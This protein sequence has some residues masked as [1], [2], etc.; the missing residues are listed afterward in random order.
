MI[1]RAYDQRHRPLSYLDLAC[2]ARPHGL[3]ASPFALLQL[4]KRIL[5]SGGSGRTP[6]FT[7]S[8]STS[9]AGRPPG[10]PAYVHEKTRGGR[11]ISERKERRDGHG[12]ESSSRS[13]MP[14]ACRLR[15]ARRSGS[16][17]PTRRP[18]FDISA[19]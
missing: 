11:D 17:L 3:A 9:A 10:E 13:N 14:P 6:V 7:R 8:D 15:L 12:N 16:A 5:R 4:P 2:L 19:Q 1:Y 18:K